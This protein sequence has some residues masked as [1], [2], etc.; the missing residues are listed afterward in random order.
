MES[1]KVRLGLVG[2]SGVAQITHLPILKRMKNVDVCAIYDADN[3]VAQQIAR[4]FSI[5]NVP[6]T[7]DEMLELGEID[8]VDIISNSTQ[9]RVPLA[10]AALKRGKHLMIEKPFASNLAE[11]REIVQAAQINQR[12]VMALMNLRFRP[13]A[14]IL[15][16]ILDNKKLGDI[17]FMKSGWLRRNEKWQLR[18]AALQN[19]RGIIQTF[20]FQLIDL[21]LWLLSDPTVKT[22]KAIH[23]NKIMTAEVE[24]SAIVLIHLENNRVFTIEVGWNMRSG[25]DFI[26]L[27]LFGTRGTARLNPLTI[28]NARDNTLIDITPSMKIFRKRPYLKSY[29]NQFSH[30]MFCVLN[31]QKVQSSGEEILKRFQII[32]AIYESAQTGKEV[33][34]A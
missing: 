4:K 28:L 33:V 17:F 15:K 32:D 2:A 27:N 3:E 1:K 20:G 16:S 14:I 22:I 34:L 7:V 9:L 26:F 18:D 10:L 6:A 24:D 12:K 29:E 19:G 23:F 5:K 25:K 13:D 21:G 11:A 8:V 30:F 31:D